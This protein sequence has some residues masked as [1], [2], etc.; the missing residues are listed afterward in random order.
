[1]FRKR[2]QLT[3]PVVHPEVGDKVPHQHVLEAESLA[4]VHEASDSKTDAQ[5][6][7]KHLA[8]VL[9]LIQRAAGVE[10]VDT[11]EQTVLLALATAL[12]LALVVIV[13]GLVGDDVQ[14]PADQLLSNQVEKGG[15]GCLFGQLGQLVNHTADPVGVLLA[16]AGHKDHVT[17]NVA[18]G[19]VVLA[20]RHLPAEVRNEQARVENPADSVVDGLGGRESLVATLM[21]KNPE[22]GAKETLEHRV[23]GPEASASRLRGNVLWRYV[24]VENVKCGREE[25]H[26]TGNIAQATDSRAFEAV[27]WDGIV[28]VLDGE[29]RNLKGV[30]VRV[31]KF[32]NR[33]VRFLLDRRINRRK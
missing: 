3:K 2:L 27:L 10:V 13:T 32:A 22:A 19:L 33:L 1:M 31:D 7:E 12:T 6:T 18:S 17:L 24:V 30:A 16:G 23:N 9:V 26:V 5:V 8:G 4:K 20:V 15:D 14:R 25:D 28:D 29:V 21:G 11:S